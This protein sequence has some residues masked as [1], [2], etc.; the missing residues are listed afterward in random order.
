MFPTPVFD[1]VG[2]GV[3][4]LVVG[5]GGWTRGNR[6]WGSGPGFSPFQ[7]HLVNENGRTPLEVDEAVA[8]MFLNWVYRKVTDTAWTG[9]PCTYPEMGS[10]QG[11]LNINWLD[12]PNGISDSRLPGNARF[13]W[14]ENQMATIFSQHASLGW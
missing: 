10:W 13:G 7:Q 1:C 12:D 2:A 4:G 5:N 3:I 14:M 8:D 9:N 11:F 6:G